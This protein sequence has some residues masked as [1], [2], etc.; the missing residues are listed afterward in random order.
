MQKFSKY[1]KIFL[2]AIFLLLAAVFLSH[3]VRAAA[4]DVGLNYAAGTGLSNAQDIRVIIAKIIRIALGF[5]GVIAVSLV[6]YAG[7]LWMTSQG[8]EEK[9]E[10]AKK[11]LKNAVIGLIIILSAFAVVSFI[12]NQLTGEGGNS[13]KA[14]GGGGVKN[15]G[16]SALGNGIIE[17]HYP[18][19]DQK[20]VPR[21]ASII[22]TF[23]ELMKAETLCK[24][25][26][27]TPTICDGDD[28]N[29]DVIRIFKKSDS[30]VCVTGSS[31]ASGCTSLVDAK[32]YT[33]ADGKTYVFAPKNYLGSPSEYI[34]YSVYLSKDLKRK[35]GDGAFLG[36]TPEEYAWSFEVSNKIDLTP[37]QVIKNSLAPAPDNIKDTVAP[38]AGASATGTITVNSEPSIY[39]EAKVLLVMK[40]MVDD[41]SVIPQTDPPTKILASWSDATATVDKSCD[42]GGEF[43][44]N[45]DSANKSIIK[46][47]DSSGISLGQGAVSGKTVAFTLCNLKLTLNSGNFTEGN[48]WTVKI[49]AMTVADTITAGDITYIASDT[50]GGANFVVGNNNT[51]ANNLKD[52]INNISSPNPDIA[53]TAS[54]NVVTVKA[55]VAGLAGNSINLSNS[56]SA[57]LT[58]VAMKDGKD[59]ID[60]VNNTCIKNP[61]QL[62]CKTDEPM[63]SAIQIEF[64]EAIMPLVVSGASDDLKDYIRVVNAVSIPVAKDGACTSD[65]DCL[66]YKCDNNKCAGNYLAGKF[67]VSNQYRTVDFLSD[68]ECGFNACGEKIYCLP[69][70]SHLRVELSAASLISCAK[71]GKADDSLCQDKSPFN[72]CDTARKFC[73]DSANKYF[74]QAN[75]AGTKIVDGIVDAAFNSLDGNRNDSAY[76]PA[77]YYNENAPVAAE[78]DSYQWSFFISNKLNLTPPKIKTPTIP[79]K[80]ESGVDL[81]K[82]ITISFDKLMLSSRL[83]TGSLT[84]KNGNEDVLHYLLNLRS[85][86]DQPLGY[87]ATNQGKQSVPGASTIDQTDVYINHSPFSN[88][89]SY[90]AQAGSGLKDIYQN[91][92]KPCA[93]P[94]CSGDANS[95]T[96]GLPCCCNGARGES[97]P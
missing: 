15:Y 53:A 50:A 54:G 59:K 9:I 47:T 4:A 69:P 39:S 20:E 16:L 34:D 11:I 17:S 83:T 95:V 6:I 74:P 45:V 73:R 19:R 56:N 58:V 79:V 90:K 78:G 85:F 82:A 61:P 46:L 93:G 44:V 68:K 62:N 38:G 36:K 67:A 2:L 5:L 8:N 24:P 52:A 64:N 87:W 77:S 10:Q 23:R 35:T 32:V 43:K 49:K 89:A 14:G 29:T 66:S 80:D 65:A 51:T 26:D 22:I 71:N 48:E 94:A 76:G 12:L 18:A 27:A 33:T 75:K 57:A 28:I 91:C 31:P 37:P 1:S 81:N 25:K 97:C 70:N 96:D 42:Q 55:K 30:A 60:E 88:A 7:W 63:N 86:L 3:S 21:N 72:T 40:P 41:P 13:N 84:I 92:F